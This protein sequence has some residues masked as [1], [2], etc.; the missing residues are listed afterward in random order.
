MDNNSDNDTQAQAP[1]LE[2][3]QGHTCTPIVT[4]DRA[5]LI[6]RF[7]KLSNRDNESLDAALE[8]ARI[9]DQLDI[10]KKDCWKQLG[11]S[12]S[13]V[14]QHR[15]LLSVPWWEPQFIPEVTY[16]HQALDSRK[17]DTDPTSP[18]YDTFNTLNTLLL[19]DIESLKAALRKQGW[20]PGAATET[21]TP[22]QSES[23]P[24]AQPE[25]PTQI[26]ET[27]RYPEWEQLKPKTY[28][29]AVEI[30]RFW[31]TTFYQ[32]L[33][34]HLFHPD[35][36]VRAVIAYRNRVQGAPT[37]RPTPYCLF[38]L[39]DPEEE[40]DLDDTR[41]ALVQGIRE[42]AGDNAWG[43][44]RAVVKAQMGDRQGIELMQVRVTENYNY[45][46]DKPKEELGMG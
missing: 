2:P 11:V 18:F 36:T 16:T 9:I 4:K 21:E 6:R 19:P 8:R 13:Y 32:A 35:V 26:S 3:D 20:K 28:R 7:R 29:P 22:N 33:K 27:L 42:L 41:D 30:S 44:G 45:K 1:P 31:D 37:K 14:K 39:I 5:A 40:M 38:I 46:P 24:E 43:V 12:Y 23:V 34:D 17:L 10:S 25:P 15:L